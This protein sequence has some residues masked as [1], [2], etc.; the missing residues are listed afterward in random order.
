MKYT[1]TVVKEPI[2]TETKI[3]T[4]VKLP[5][6]DKPIQVITF[7]KYRDAETIA[8][9]KAF[10]INDSVIL[11]GKEERNPKNKELQI[12]VNKAYIANG[13]TFSKQAGVDPQYA[14][15]PDVDFIAGGLSS[16]NNKLIVMSE[17]REGRKQY[18]TD[19]DYYWYKNSEMKTPTT[20]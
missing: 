1:G 14:I 9:M 11:Y 13:K 16:Y 17:P 15:D 6:A 8:N 18:F 12:I 2:V 10:K 20:F 7:P 4:A 5:N 3:T 19:G